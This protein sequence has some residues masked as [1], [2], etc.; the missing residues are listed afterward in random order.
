M[1]EPMSIVSAAG[2]AFSAIGFLITTLSKLHEKGLELVECQERLQTYQLELSVCLSRMHTW[3]SIWIRDPPF[4]PEMYKYFWSAKYDDII[5]G[6]AL[7]DELSQKI[8]D[9]I[10]GHG[11]E[12]EARN[13]REKKEKAGR[14]EGSTKTS[15]FEVP[16]RRK[17]RDQQKQDNMPQEDDWSDWESVTLSLRREPDAKPE[18]RDVDVLYRVAFALFKNQSL[19][20]KL[21]RLKSGIGNIFEL[22][23]TQFQR[24]QSNSFKKIPT[25]KK[26]QQAEELKVWV[27]KL[28]SFA[29][30]LYEAYQG[31][32]RTQRWALELRLPDNRGNVE[33]WSRA[34]L[35]DLDFTLFIKDDQQCWTERRVRFCYDKDAPDIQQSAR[36]LPKDVVDL[37]LA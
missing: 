2:F 3:T 18:V 1:L 34:A 22:S 23:Q 20:E 10:S 16:W 4:A 17:A 29:K 28:S 19:G 9:E 33:K 8:A 14:A 24:L 21:A 26:I 25:G 6:F 12:R 5:Q 13:H 15:R 32:E 36:E 30:A 27:D 11:E 35:L 31:Q 7:M 37:A